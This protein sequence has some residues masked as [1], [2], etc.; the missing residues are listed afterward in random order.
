MLSEYPEYFL[1]NKYGH[2]MRED[3]LDKMYHNIFHIIYNKNV[4]KFITYIIFILSFL[5]FEIQ[6]IIS[7]QKAIIIVK[8]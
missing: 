2:K 6:S 4:K 8:V 3:V 1:Q 5:K 7:F